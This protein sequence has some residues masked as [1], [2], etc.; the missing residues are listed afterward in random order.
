MSSHELETA[1]VKA[2]LG[3]ALQRGD[4]RFLAVQG[5]ATF[6]P[7]IDDNKETS[8]IHNTDNF[9][10]IDKSGDFFIDV[11]DP[12]LKHQ[13]LAVKYAEK[14]NPKLLQAIKNG[15]RCN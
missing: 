9:R 11:N 7:G 6:F 12:N 10:Y 1:D 5:F 3:K 4:C 8:K 2:D 15:Q 13:G 14:Y